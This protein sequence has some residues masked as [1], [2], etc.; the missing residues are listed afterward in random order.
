MKK[1]N[2]QPDQPANTA[3]E[4]TKGEMV[5]KAGADNEHAFGKGRK[6][7]DLKIGDNWICRVSGDNGFEEA[8]ANAGRIV[9]CWNGYDKLQGD[10]QKMSE[11]FATMTTLQQNGFKENQKLKADNED[12]K[13]QLNAE[14]DYQYAQRQEIEALKE[15]IQNILADY[16]ETAAHYTNDKGE[17][18]IQ[19]EIK[20]STFESLKAAI[21]KHSVK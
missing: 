5:M 18:M 3:G 13:K 11:S 19:L 17:K 16:N 7:F 21:S 20:E 2:T 1:T 4:W 10:I 15:A 12:L 9:E 8:K 6:T 14:S